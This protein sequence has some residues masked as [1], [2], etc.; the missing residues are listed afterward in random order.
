MHS[1]SPFLIKTSDKRRP[2]NKS[3][4]QW[5]WGGG[6]MKQRHGDSLTIPLTAISTLL[7]HLDVKT[8][9]VCTL[10][11]D[12]DGDDDDNDDDDNDDTL[13]SMKTTSVPRVPASITGDTLTLQ[14]CVSLTQHRFSS[15]Y[16]QQDLFSLTLKNIVDSLYH[17]PHCSRLECEVVL[18]SFQSCKNESHQHGREL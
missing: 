12:D 17:L 14:K 10:T 18:L 9:W 13:T 11:L 2:R 5:R 1:C 8:W 6:T 16:A 4:A 15:L 7:S 3:R